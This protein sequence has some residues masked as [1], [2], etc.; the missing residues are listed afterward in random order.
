MSGFPPEIETFHNL[1]LSLKGIE[2]ITCG[3][4]NLEGIDSEILSQSDCA[5][6][7]HATLLRTNG[8]HAKEVL[9]QFEFVIVRTTDGLIA[10]EFLAWFIRDQAR[11]G[12]KIQLRPFALPPETP[13]G[14]QL[15]TTLKFHIDLFQDGIDETLE[16]LFVTVEKINKTLALAINVYIN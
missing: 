11:S 1:V 6:M 14:T 7:P 13:N 8:G 15:G 2:S 3:V 4:E 10:L 9:C 16:P 12:T 5:H